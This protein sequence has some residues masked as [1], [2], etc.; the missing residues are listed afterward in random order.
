[1]NH[2][3]NEEWMACLYGEA[4]A[5]AKAS[6]EAHLAVCP[7]CRERVEAWKRAMACLD[8][9]RATWAPPARGGGAWRAWVRPAVAAAVLL[10]V[11]LGLGRSM[12][13]SRA[14][15]REELARAKGELEAEVR[16]RYQADLRE[17]AV[18]TVRATTLENRRWLDGV[19]AQWAAAR[20]EDR[21]L[22]EAALGQMEERRAA[23]SAAVRAGLFGLARYTGS[24]FDQAQSQFN[25]ISGV[26]WPA[27]TPGGPGSETST[28]SIP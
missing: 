4:D 23:D 7:E 14:E 25:Q 16:E 12:G 9:D 24:G 15:I 17:I 3:T 18:A 28:P 22:V 13:P 27:A 21:R 5:R 11:G 2:P 6:A 20:V 8:E 1:M 26:K 10:G 19:S